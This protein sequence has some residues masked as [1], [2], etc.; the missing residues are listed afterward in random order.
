MQAKKTVFFHVEGKSDKVFIDHIIDCFTHRKTVY[1]RK[2][3]SANGGS[4]T[5]IIN[6][7]IHRVGDTDYTTRIIV[8]D[9]DKPIPLAL[10]E[11]ASSRARFHFLLPP[12]KR[13]EIEALFWEIFHPD[14][15]LAGGYKISFYE[16]NKTEKTDVLTKNDCKRLFTKEVLSGARVHCSRLNTLLTVCETGEWGDYPDC[17]PYVEQ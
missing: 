8:M 16:E 17:N 1:V 10:Y 14:K 7:A 2:P 11:E 4:P 15:K 9:N 13:T 12:G 5:S 6:G 3:A